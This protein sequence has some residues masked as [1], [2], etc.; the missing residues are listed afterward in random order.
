MP[1]DEVDLAS[2]HPLVADHDLYTPSLQ[3]VGGNLLTE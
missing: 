2:A 1:D 3:E